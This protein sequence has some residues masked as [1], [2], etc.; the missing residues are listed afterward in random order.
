MFVFG[1]PFHQVLRKHCN[2]L[3]RFI[4]YIKESSMNTAPGF[5][6]D[7]PFNFI[8]ILVETF[9]SGNDVS[10]NETTSRTKIQVS[11]SQ[12]FIFFET[13]EYAQ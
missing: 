4:S 3:R 2:L 6:D 13:Y 12:H 10:Q 5:H 8:F 9:D 11:Y 1:K 7:R